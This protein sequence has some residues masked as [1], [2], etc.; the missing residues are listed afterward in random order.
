MPKAPAV[1]GG[2]AVVASA[3][4]GDGRG[5]SPWGSGNNA[6]N[7]SPRAGSPRA[8]IGGRSNAYTKTS[9]VSGLIQHRRVQIH[10]SSY[11]HLNHQFY[12]IAML[13]PEHILSEAARAA[14]ADVQVVQ[15]AKKA[16]TGSFAPGFE[17]PP[18]P[19]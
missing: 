11:L 12:K 1:R 4:S 6:L 13:L 8:G 5:G 15:V 3:S 7:R 2:K 10:T 18:P 17:P 14:Q 16:R 9:P 19:Q